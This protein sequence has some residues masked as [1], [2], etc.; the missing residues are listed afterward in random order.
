MSFS[1]PSH[2]LSLTPN[3]T[4]SPV[5]LSPWGPQLVADRL[6]AI[7]PSLASFTRVADKPGGNVE[8]VSTSPVILEPPHYILD[9]STSLPTRL[10]RLLRLHCLED[11]YETD[12]PRNGRSKS[13]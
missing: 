10:A 12:R 8:G 9:V 13:R 7:A 3:F 1:K 5:P 2:Q 11:L 6:I 4:D